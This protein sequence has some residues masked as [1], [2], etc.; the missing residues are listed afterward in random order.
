MITDYIPEPVKCVD[1]K[2][3]FYVKYPQPVERCPDCEY[4]KSER[5]NKKPT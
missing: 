2:K 1:C 5:K 4:L 3:T